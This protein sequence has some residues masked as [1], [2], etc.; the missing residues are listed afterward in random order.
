MA[1]VCKKMFMYRPTY[2]VKVHVCT[3][4]M[5]ANEKVLLQ[6]CKQPGEQTR[7]HWPWLVCRYFLTAGGV[8][9]GSPTRNG[10]LFPAYVCARKLCVLF[11][12][13]FSFAGKIRSR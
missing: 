2:G 13:S 5:Y 3:C 8:P 6:R 4:Y 11:L 1:G 9:P 10:D 7:N 12:E